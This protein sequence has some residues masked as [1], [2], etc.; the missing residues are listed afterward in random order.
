MCYPRKSVIRTKEAEYHDLMT[1]PQGENEP[2]KKAY[3][4]AYAKTKDIL[5]KLFYIRGKDEHAPAV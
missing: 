1:S 4:N 3:A 2:K 5:R